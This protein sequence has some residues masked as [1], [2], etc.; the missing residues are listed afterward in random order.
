[1]SAHPPRRRTAT[2]AHLRPARAS[3]AGAVAK[4]LGELGYPCT[5]EDAS[6]RIAVVLDDTRQRLLVADLHGD[7]CGLLALDFLYYLP[8]GRLSCRITALVVAESHRRYG[9]GR[10]LVR[11]AE[12]LA[13][14]EGAARIELTTAAH[15]HEAH[16]FYRSCGYEESSVRFVK[17]LGD[18]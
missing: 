4:L 5:R 18:A 1:M 15:R 6:A 3:D 10:E 7:L 9:L 8:L 12:H 17:R 16:A 13:R 14:H 2:P 11:E